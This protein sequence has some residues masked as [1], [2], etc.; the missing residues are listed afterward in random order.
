MLV[1]QLPS[2]TE[3]T[4][5]LSFETSGHWLKEANLEI[6]KDK[7]IELG[8]RLACKSPNRRVIL[9]KKRLGKRKIKK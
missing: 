4:H 8:L 5:L 1:E 9:Y 7:T 3:V 2:E 6:K